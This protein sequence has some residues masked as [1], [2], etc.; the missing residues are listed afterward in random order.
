[1][2]ETALSSTKVS[3]IALSSSCCSLEI[4][5]WLLIWCFLLQEAIARLQLAILDDT[6]DEL[7]LDQAFSTM[8]VTSGLCPKLL[9]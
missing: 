8:A 7:E 2:R 6:G 1:M 4:S 5:F 9:S 3:D